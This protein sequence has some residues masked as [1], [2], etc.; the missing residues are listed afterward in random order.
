MPRLDHLRNFVYEC[1]VREMAQMEDEVRNRVT[2]QATSMAR[3]RSRVGETA[4]QVNRNG[5]AQVKLAYVAYK[6]LIVRGKSAT[7]G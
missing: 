5:E 6:M 7:Q 3:T 4:A 2:S 1:K